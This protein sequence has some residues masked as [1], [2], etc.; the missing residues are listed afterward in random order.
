MRR[1]DQSSFVRGKNPESDKSGTPGRL[2]TELWLQDRGRRTVVENP[3]LPQ[4]RSC[5]QMGGVPRSFFKELQV[6]HSP[7][8]GKLH[9]N[10]DR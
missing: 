4:I 7:Q 8:N 9:H 2:K 1:T 3:G 5:S 6:N 10:D